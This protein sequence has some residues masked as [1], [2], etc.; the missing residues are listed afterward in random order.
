MD[1]PVRRVMVGE[2]VGPER[3]GAAMSID[4][5]TNNASRMLGPTVGGLLL[6]GVGIAGAFALG[7]LLYTAALAAAIAVRYRNPVLPGAPAPALVRIAEGLMLARRDPRLLGTLVVTIVFNLFGWPFT[8]MVPVIAHDDL[9]LG[10]E[11]IGVI[12]SMEGVGAFGGALAIA[13]FARPAHYARLFVAGMVA[14]LVM[15]TLF[16]LAADP[17]LAGL[18][19]VLTGFGQAGFSVMQATLVYLATPAE[20]RGRIFGVLAVCIGV[21]PIGFVHIGLLADAIGARAATIALGLEGLVALLLTWPLWRGLVRAEG[22]ASP[23]GLSSTITG[24]ELRRISHITPTRS[25]MPT[26]SRSKVP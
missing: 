12:A 3:M 9:G 10:A 8:S 16:A 22:A 2:V 26:I 23:S 15:L 7:A 25:E 18:A 19:L 21:G 14:Y 17:I 20:M 24:M 6:A 1:N 5:G 13:L 4:V 11:G